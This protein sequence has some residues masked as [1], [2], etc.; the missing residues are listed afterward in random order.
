M[1][2][3]IYGNVSIDSISVSF[4]VMVT[5]LKWTMHTHHYHFLKKIMTCICKSAACNKNEVYL[6]F[7]AL[8]YIYTH[9]VKA[10]QC[11]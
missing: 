1:L 10:I 9:T 7:Q 11:K 2:T 6:I 5:D 8:Y 4:T 3:S